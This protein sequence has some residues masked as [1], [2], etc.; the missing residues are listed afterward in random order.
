MLV[1]LL[2][3]KEKWCSVKVLRP[4][5]GK[6]ETFKIGINKKPETFRFGFLIYASPVGPKFNGIGGC[7]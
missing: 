2:K 4:I 1:I 6:K 5:Y 7:S 3:G